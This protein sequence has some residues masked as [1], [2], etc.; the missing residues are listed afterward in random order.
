MPAE[1]TRYL[2]PKADSIYV[3]RWLGNT[4]R[5]P[6]NVYS[7][8]G[9]VSGSSGNLSRCP[10][11]EKYSDLN[12][13]LWNRNTQNALKKQTSHLLTLT[14]EPDNYPDERETYPSHWWTLPSHRKTLTAH[15][16]RKNCYWKKLS[17]SAHYLWTGL[18][19]PSRIVVWIRLD[20]RL[21]PSL[22]R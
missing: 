4:S 14:G 7:S 2:A 17:F 6:V 18:F 15:R 12:L 22:F 5:S 11:C 9:N 19:K 1:N 13:F 3:S 20:H 16:D 8:S 21:Q 10:V